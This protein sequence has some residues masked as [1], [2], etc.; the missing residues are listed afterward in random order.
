MSQLML[1]L[2]ILL[3]VTVIPVMIAARIVRA[4][5]TGIGAALLSLFLQMV[6]AGGMLQLPL[7]ATAAVIA[8]VV[9]G[10]AIYAFTLDTTMLK[11]LVVSILVSAIAGAVLMLAAGSLLTGS[12]L[13]GKP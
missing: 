11:G 8:S 1:G 10:A 3:A 4:G 2:A 5:N 7:N 6:L 12:A 13:I 9:G